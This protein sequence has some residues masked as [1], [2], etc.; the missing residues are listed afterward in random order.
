M[1]IS[2]SGRPASTI[3]LDNYGIEPRNEGRLPLPLV[4]EVCSSDLN[5]Y[6]TKHENRK[7]YAVTF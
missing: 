4:T 7:I 5:G 3:L 1:W 2:Y 6:N